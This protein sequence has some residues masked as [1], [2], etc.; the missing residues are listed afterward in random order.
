M[1]FDPTS[2]I[3]G[4][5]GSALSAGLGIYQYEKGLQDQKSNA[6]PE[7]QIPDEIKQNLSQAEMMALEGLPAEQKQQYIQNLQ[8]SA[9]FGLRN[10]SSRKGGLAGLSGVVQSQNDAYGNLLSADAQARRENQKLAMQR[11]DISAQYKDQAFQLNKLNPY[12]ERTA[13][14]QAL[15]GAGMQNIGGAVGQLAKGIGG[16]NSGYGSGYGKRPTG[17]AGG[18]GLNSMFGDYNVDPS[19]VA[20]MS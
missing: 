4:G 3:A 7:Y 2:L 8:R 18:G 10:I 6:R 20:G 5:V 1:A 17:G 13:Q 12:Y 11:G 9:N 19:E 16:M 14:D 15:M